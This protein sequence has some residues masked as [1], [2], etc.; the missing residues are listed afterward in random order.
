VIDIN[1]TGVTIMTEISFVTTNCPWTSIEITAPSSFTLITLYAPSAL[2]FLFCASGTVGTFNS[3]DIYVLI[4]STLSIPAA[5][6]VVTFQL[7]ACV[8]DILQ[9]LCWE[10]TGYS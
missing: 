1:R 3:S 5:K 2:S 7:G 9:T 4:L 8:V 10:V 6:Y